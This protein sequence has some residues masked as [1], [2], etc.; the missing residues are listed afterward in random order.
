M[1]VP[2]A[3]RRVT[4]WSGAL[5]TRDPGIAETQLTGVPD[6]RCTIRA[7]ALMLRRIRVTPLSLWC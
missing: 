3:T 5:Q 7:H 2:G 1:R 4:K 6:Q